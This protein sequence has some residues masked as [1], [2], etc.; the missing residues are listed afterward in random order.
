MG[1]AITVADSVPL[2]LDGNHGDNSVLPG[3]K[4]S[5]PHAMYSSRSKAP[6]GDP[7][8]PIYLAERVMLASPNSEPFKLRH[9][10]PASE[11]SHERASDIST[12]PM[13]GRTPRSHKPNPSPRTTQTSRATPRTSDN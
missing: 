4:T 2:N 3:S 1:P 5:E 8:K 6:T 13:C 9:P 10:I 12:V 11:P 7:M